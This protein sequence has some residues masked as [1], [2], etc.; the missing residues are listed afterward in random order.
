MSL[1]N[2]TKKE[3]NRVELEIEVDAATFNAAVNA[4]YKKDIKKMNIPG[5]RRG[6]APRAFVEKIYGTGVFYE[7]AVNDVYPAALDEAIKES[8]YEYV[9]DQIDFD[10]TSVGEDGLK[11]TAVITVKPEVKLGEYKGLKAT[12]TITPVTDADVDAEIDRLRERNAR[13]ISVE[14]RAAEMG[15]TVTFDFE[16]F[17]DG[18][19]FEGGKAENHSLLL[20]SGQFIPGFE[21]Q[22]VGKKIDEE[23]DVNVTFP[24]EYHAKELAGKPA[25]FRC[26]I[27]E[28][29][30]KELPE[31]NDD[32]AKDVSDFDTLDELKADARKKQEEQRAAAADETVSA[33]LVDGLIGILD[34]DIPEAMF[35]NAVNDAVRD[36]DYRLQSQGLNMEMYM[37]YTGMDMEAFRGNFREQAEKQVKMRLILE[38]IAKLENIV[39]SEEDLEKEYTRY[40]EMYQMEA[41][42]VKAFI[43]AAELGKDIAVEKAMDLVKEAAVITDKKPAAKKSTAKSTASKAKKAD[44]A[45]A[46]PKK[47]AAKKTTKKAAE[48]EEK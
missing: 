40:A 7:T 30:T 4:A 41:D 3:N 17:V 9:E 46:A 31:L 20:G 29:Q 8:G 38:E 43:P 37:K 27:H 19:A 45:E 28:I 34:A 26:K 5:F 11:F 16:G 21:E 1:K 15:D 6:K 14:D 32:F 10:V 33:Q 35:V 47:P 22:L 25:V 42:K 18:E 48:T 12:R 13:M 39:A 44:D 23:C 2:A 24:E 36:F